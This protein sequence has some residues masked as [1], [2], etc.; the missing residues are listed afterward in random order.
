[1]LT[2]TL[3]GMMLLLF[4]LNVPITFSVGLAAA[5]A[6]LTMPHV[7]LE[8]IVQRMFFGLNSFLILSVPFFLLFGE[9][10]ESAKITDRLIAFTLSLIGRL[11]GGLGHVTVATECVLSGVTGSGAGDAAALGS[12]LVALTIALG[13]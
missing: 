13:G 12:V 6:L 10:M 3:F 4:L 1:M 2:V 8:V 7:S 11:R 5:S 9:L